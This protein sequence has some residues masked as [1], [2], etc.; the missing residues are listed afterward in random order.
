[1]S[2]G[3]ETEA[4]CQ[5][6]EP[7]KYCPTQGLHTPFANCSA[8]YYCTANATTASPTD[9]GVT[10]DVCPLG[11]YCPVGTG[12]PVPCPAGSYTNTTQNAQCLVCPAGMFCTN[13]QTPELC[14]LGFH[15]PAGTGSDW[16]SCPPGTFGASLGLQNVTECSQCTGGYYCHVANLTAPAGP[17]DAGY[18]C[19]SVAKPQL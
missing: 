2:P 11:H 3:L 6:C 7:G 10:G 1:M 17:C 15:C 8:G 19:R 13:G 4:Q 5:A 18:Y 16:Q 9:G 12:T 14:P